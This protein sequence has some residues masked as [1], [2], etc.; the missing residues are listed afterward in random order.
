MTAA[1]PFL[2]E[3]QADFDKCLLNFSTHTWAA[4]AR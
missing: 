3:K 4:P 1:A 2:P